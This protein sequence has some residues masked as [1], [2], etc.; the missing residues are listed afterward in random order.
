M[1]DQC[2]EGELKFGIVRQQKEL[3]IDINHRLACLIWAFCDKI[4]AQSCEEC[5]LCPDIVPISTR[6]HLKG[7]HLH[8][9]STL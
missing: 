7:G 8:R 5:M 3:I 1:A 4:L 2:N 6:V 9:E